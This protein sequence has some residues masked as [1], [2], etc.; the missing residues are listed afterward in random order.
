MP[1]SC[2]WSCAEVASD[3]DA[4][5][6]DYVIDQI[7]ATMPGFDR[8]GSFAK[9]LGLGAYLAARAVVPCHVGGVQLCF[10][11]SCVR[12]P[13]WRPRRSMALAGARCPFPDPPSISRQI[14]AGR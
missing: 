7:A 5:P 8:I 12:H 10:R 6:R 3:D 2:R 1:S 14:D 13:A 9:F 11:V 4:K